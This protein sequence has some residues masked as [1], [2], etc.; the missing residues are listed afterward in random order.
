MLPVGETYIELLQGSTPDSGA[1]KWLNENGQ[2]LFH[3]CFEV[4]D[5]DAALAE[6]KAKGTPLLQRNPGPRPRQLPHRLYRPE[7]DRQYAVRAGRD[8]KGR[9][10][11]ALTAVASPL[12]GASRDPPV[13]RSSCGQVGPGLRREAMGRRRLVGLPD[14]E[15]HVYQGRQSAS[16]VPD[17]GAV[18]MRVRAEPTAYSTGAQADRRPG[19]AAYGS[20]GRA[21]RHDPGRFRDR[22]DIGTDR[23][24][25][26][27]RH[28]AAPGEQPEHGE[29]GLDN[30]LLRPAACLQA[31]PPTASR[32]TA[33]ATPTCTSTTGCCAASTT[34]PTPSIAL[35]FNRCARQRPV[36]R[37]SC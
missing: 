32:S 36:S 27:L 22:T 29:P 15:H 34:L 17:G 13:S 12:P 19:T 28:R 6:L 23:H 3:I 37:A 11:R 5:I 31:Q 35:A 18:G 21:D 8:A 14:V 9:S 7:G 20:L 33:R 25:P 30:Y 16:G 24:R 4:E 2:S 10:R 26:R 1:T